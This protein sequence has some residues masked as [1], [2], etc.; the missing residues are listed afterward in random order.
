MFTLRNNTL[1][2]SLS[3]CVLWGSLATAAVSPVTIHEDKPKYAQEIK[4]PQGFKSA[5]TNAAIR[6]FIAKNQS[7]FRKSLKKEAHTS[8]APGKTSLDITYSIP[9]ESKNALSVRFD[10]S[11]YHQGAAHPENKV[12]VLNFIKGK[13]VQLSDLFIPKVNYLKTISAYSNKYITDKKISEKTWISEGTAPTPANYAVWFFNKKGISILFDSYQVAA[14][15]YGPQIVTIPKSLISH[16]VKPEIN[17][18]L[19][20]LND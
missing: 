10:I 4:Y 16:L 19:W 14:Y 11:I 18:M 15:V 8:D 12:E 3:L 5:D 6:D 20:S 7:A 2:V 9:F 1:K 13:K 17:K